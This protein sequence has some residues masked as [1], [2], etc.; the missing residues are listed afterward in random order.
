MV[1]KFATWRMITDQN[2]RTDR[3]TNR[4]SCQIS[5]TGTRSDI[6][7]RTITR[8]NQ[9][10]DIRTIFGQNAEETFKRKNGISQI[11]TPSSDIIPKTTYKRKEWSQKTEPRSPSDTLPRTIFKKRIASGDGY[12]PTLG[13]NTEGSIQ[14]E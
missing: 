12:T 7:S 10:I 3:E 6:I 5:Q 8:W 14:K 9:K 2:E 1:V 11:Y 4:G 13:Q